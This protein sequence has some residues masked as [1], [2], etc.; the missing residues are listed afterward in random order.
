VPLLPRI[1]KKCR[2]NQTV[3]CKY[4]EYGTGSLGQT[5]A[6]ALIFILVVAYSFADGDLTV[7]K[8]CKNQA[9]KLSDSTTTQRLG[10]TN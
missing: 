9:C 6:V 8:S 1:N 3:H 5:A 7:P 10:N 4:F 2:D